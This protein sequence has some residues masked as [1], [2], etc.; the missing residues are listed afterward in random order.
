MT[1]R[2]P[3]PLRIV[4]LGGLLGLVSGVGETR[5][6]NHASPSIPITDPVYDDLDV[7]AAHGLIQDLI[8]GQKPFSRSEIARLL[9]AARGRLD[10]FEDISSRE[11]LEELLTQLER[12][13][14]TAIKNQKDPSATPKFRVE[15]LS[16]AVFLATTT[17][18]PPRPYFDNTAIRAAD[19]GVNRYSG[20]RHTTDGVQFVLETTHDAQ[21]TRY[22]SLFFNP[23]LQLEPLNNQL[24]EE[25][26]F[27]LNEGYVT[28]DFFNTRID[29][30]RKQIAWGQSR[31]GGVMFSA[32]ARALDAIQLTNSQPWQ[33]PVLGHLKYSFFFA[34]LGPEQNFSYPFITGGRISVLPWSFLE[35]GISRAMIFGGDGSP[36]GSAWE[37]FQEFFGVRSSLTQNVNNAISGF[38]FRASIP[39]LRSATA[40]GEFYFDDFNLGHLFRSFVQDAGIVAGIFL[41][42]LD[43]TGRL[44]LRVEGRKMS[45]VMYKHG[46]WLNGWTLNG[47]ILG[48]PLGPDAES[49]S[50]QVLWR[51]SPDTRLSAEA[52]LERIDSDVYTS[53]TS[54]RSAIINGPAEIR[55][56]PIVHASHRFN[57]TWLGS[58]KLGYEH[59]WNFAFTPG[60]ARNNLLLHVGMTLN[61]A[62]R[63][64]FE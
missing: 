58:L 7:L 2:L 32:N 42:R 26:K 57:G 60:R 39:Q 51:L 25:N 41:P 24:P 54:G 1:F 40:Y 23:R 4:V 62:G 38:E 36:Q 22:F 9:L 19:S 64:S 43:A 29:I 18:S 15:A 63:F 44:S 37:M 27:F 12:H 59:V 21:I 55:L 49:L 45:P 61:T 52:F 20:G 46:N 3:S 17:D 53:D 13:F 16:Q 31:L 8:Q 14:E 28:A 34:T 35:F 6:F 11:F 10:R 5:G 48:D 56:R 33:I 47:L 30:G 50:G